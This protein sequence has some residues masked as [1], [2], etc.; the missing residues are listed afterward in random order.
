MHVASKKPQGGRVHRAFAPAIEQPKIIVERPLKLVV[1]TT[2]A[3]ELRHNEKTEMDFSMP[4]M[5]IG[6]L[7][8]GIALA[9]W[10]AVRAI[11][12]AKRGSKSASLLGLGMDLANPT[13]PPRAHLEEIDSEMHGKKRSDS[14]DPK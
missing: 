5:W 6:A 11:R 1:L 9:V 7:A 4:L 3:G 2:I 14:S 12:W 13:P 8:V 10:M